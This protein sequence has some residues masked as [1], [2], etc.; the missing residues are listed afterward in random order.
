MPPTPPPRGSVR[1]AAVV[2]EEI[3]ALWQQA[4]GTLNPEQRARYGRLLED[5]E[6]A[7]RAEVT[8]AA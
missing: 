6:Q 7:V 1:S 8:E 5:W 3:R 2:N 4:D